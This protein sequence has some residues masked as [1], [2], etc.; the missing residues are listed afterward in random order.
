MAALVPPITL[1]RDNRATGQK[2][3]AEAGPYYVFGFTEICRFI[4]LYRSRVDIFL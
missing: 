1:H 2:P 3:G 4:L